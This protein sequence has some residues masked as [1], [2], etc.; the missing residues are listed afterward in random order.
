MN[1]AKKA[2]FFFFRDGESRLLSSIYSCFVDPS[3]SQAK[4]D[5]MFDPRLFI[6][7]KDN[8]TAK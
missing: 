4:D 1:R 3:L 2:T 5:E 6:G 8:R 7:F